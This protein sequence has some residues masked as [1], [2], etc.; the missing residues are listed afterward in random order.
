[1]RLNLVLQLAS[2]FPLIPM[3]TSA[4]HSLFQ[5]W[6]PVQ[7]SWSHSVEQQNLVGGG[8]TVRPAEVGRLLAAN[9]PASPPQLPIMTM[10]EV[11]VFVSPSLPSRYNHLL[12]TYSHV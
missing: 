5:P 7:V 9:C 8:V 2:L 12:E 3:E 6:D 1:M 10:A 4:Q 11:L